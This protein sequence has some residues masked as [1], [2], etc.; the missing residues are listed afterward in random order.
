MTKTYLNEY[1][2]AIKGAAR[3]HRKIGRLNERIERLKA[4]TARLITLADLN[5]LGDNPIV[6]RAAAEIGWV[7][8]TPAEREELVRILKELHG[9]SDAS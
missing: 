1:R 9:V 7:R 5:G 8:M 6:V 4:V 2:G 3:L